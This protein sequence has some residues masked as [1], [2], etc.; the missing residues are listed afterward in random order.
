LFGLLLAVL[1]SDQAAVGIGV[2]VGGAR[3]TR[4]ELSG[5]LGAGMQQQQRQGG[6]VMG[7]RSGY[8]V[9]W[10][11]GTARW[12]SKERRFQLVYIVAAVMGLACRIESW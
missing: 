1:Y 6:G 9:V 11:K 12:Y 5:S 2:G 10:Q 4:D 3:E 8:G 7:R